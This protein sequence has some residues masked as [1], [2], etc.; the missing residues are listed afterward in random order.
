MTLRPCM[1]S[2][3][4]L[5]LVGASACSDLDRLKQTP[6]HKWVNEFRWTYQRYMQ[7]SPDGSQILYSDGAYPDAVSELS[8]IDFGWFERDWEMPGLYAVSLDGF[9]TQQI[10]AP[11]VN[12][13]TGEVPFRRIGQMLHFDVSPDG[14]QIAYSTCR[15]AEIFNDARTDISSNYC[16]EGYEIVTANIDGTEVTRLTNNKH[17][18]NFP[19]WSPDVGR[20]AFISDPPRSRVDPRADRD[21][22][23]FWGVTGRLIV[24]D[25]ATGRTKNVTRSLG[26]R[27]AAHPPTW[28][29]DGRHIAFVAYEDHEY[30]NRDIP[31]PEDEFFKSDVFR[32]RVVYVVEPDG[33]NLTRISDAF[34]EPSWSPDGG[35]LALAVPVS[36]SK[37]G[38]HLY[39]FAPDGSDPVLVTE[40][41]ENLGRLSYPEPFWWGKVY[42]SPDGSR[43][44]Y[45][46]PETRVT[47]LEDRCRVCVVTV[48]GGHVINAAPFRTNSVHVFGDAPGRMPDLL[49]WSPDGSRIAVLPREQNLLYT[50]DRDG[51][52]PRVVVPSEEAGKSKAEVIESCT[53]PAVV[54][55]PEG[56]PGL[57][58]DCRILLS[59]RYVLGGNAFR[60]LS[61][62]TPI[63]ELEPT[64]SLHNPHRFGLDIRGEPPRVQGI[65]FGAYLG[66]HGCCH[67]FLGRIPPELGNLAKLEVLDLSSNDL[68]GI[69]PPELGNLAILE[70]LD[71]TG[72]D[73]TG[74][75]PPELGN[76]ANL[77]ILD[78][79][80]NELTG[81]IPAELGNLFNLKEL[82]LARTDL[83]GPL[84]P[85][86]GK[87]INL[88][89]LDLS[90]TALSGPMPPELAG[91]VNLRIL[92][93]GATN[94]SGCVPA[95]LPHIWLVAS[96]LQRCKQ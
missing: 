60:Y 70:V 87:L 16:K 94:L 56:N 35:R 96:G 4:F 32:R 52:D 77:R 83:S 55:D 18:D 73:L 86:L 53:D 91:L 36:E 39:T 15:F 45:T 88:E 12:S 62:Y 23:S 11:I 76:L 19:V 78:L 25:M 72:N 38:S 92:N 71:L 46:R 93:I 3:L 17:F 74:S 90:H 24:H 47:P 69:I 57:V 20:I 61:P 9:S 14:S 22:P 80:L 79:R 84:P 40:I 65:Y 89:E 31:T 51:N 50:I 5:A 10:V 48:D 58:K 42:W 85:E 8:W 26:D 44:M 34:S 66:D 59:S 64:P 1:L 28:S 33:S 68:T 49:A 75:I 37:P 27:V 21:A 63:T 43:I 54:P 13:G 29:P 41:T 67:E 2:M 7:W 6:D 81:S 82:K 30:V 95:E